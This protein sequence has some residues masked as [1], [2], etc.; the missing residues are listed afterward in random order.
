MERL[1][2]FGADASRLPDMREHGEQG[3]L[4]AN[5]REDVD[6][7]LQGGT[8]LTL[9]AED[10][11]YEDGA[12]AVRGE[13]IVDVGPRAEVRGRVE[14]TETLDAAGGLI[15]PGLVNAHS[16]VAMTIFRGVMDDVPLDK[17]LDRIWKLEMAHATAEN[18]RAGTELAFAEMIRAGVT[19][20]SDM[21][22]HRDVTTEVAEEVGFR[23]HNGPAFIDFE[24]P[25]GIQ[26]ENRLR[27]A[28]EYIERYRDHPLV[29]LGVQAHS[30]YSV[31]QEL[32][33]QCRMLMEAYGITFV[34]HAAETA[35]EVETVQ[36]RFGKTPVEL[37]DE[38]DL[39]TP[40]TLLAHG[41]HLRDDEIALIAERGATV[42]H[43]PQSN[44]KLGSGV[45][46]VPDLLAA[47]V[48]VGLG[49]DGAASNNDLDMWDELRT[50]ALVHK[51]VCEDPTVL[52]ARDVLHIATVGSARAMGLQ[53]EIGSLE[54]GK[55][56]DVILLDVDRL[57]ATPIYDLY[58]HLVYS[59][60][61]DDVR[62]VLINGRL[63]MRD[64]TLL[65]LDEA[66]AK[67]KVREI[68]KTITT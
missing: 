13:W 68:R 60:D 50:A 44:L 25:D 66:A 29:A 23:L 4:M 8:V 48:G 33:E 47:G 39:L 28:H 61:K 40:N 15:M 52:P 41:V 55:R 67:V 11:I 62:T 36:E 59:A 53:D 51:G 16:H 32:L 26:P 42:V 27:L 12:V 30:T 6:L 38:L 64:R 31:P 46:R 37:L 34:T 19:A 24:G 45:A 5:T 2:A 43:C 18:V 9:D 17:W 3:G 1:S 58:S 65:T 21:Y 35:D 20:V 7:L 63:V 49:T 56:A 22:W 54:A 10:R 57:H 14:A